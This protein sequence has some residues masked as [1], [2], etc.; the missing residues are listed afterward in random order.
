MAALQPPAILV[1]QAPATPLANVQHP[2]HAIINANADL[3]HPGNEPVT[4]LNALFT[5][6]IAYIYPNINLENMTRLQ[7]EFSQ[8]NRTSRFQLIEGII[9]TNAVV[10]PGGQPTYQLSQDMVAL[11]NADRNISLWGIN[12]GY[13]GNPE[14]L[15]LI[16]EL[17]AIQLLSFVKPNLTSL[18]RAIRD[19]L[20]ILNRIIEVDKNIVGPVGVDGA[21]RPAGAS[22]A[23]KY[24]KYKQKYLK[25]KKELSN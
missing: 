9:I 17:A 25:L 23:R 19:K 7:A 6:V 3:L 16:D 1:Q 8:L 14:W 13:S 5:Y 21:L 22:R 2:N 11:I 20:R 15:G 24:L 18:F 10:A 4:N 12:N